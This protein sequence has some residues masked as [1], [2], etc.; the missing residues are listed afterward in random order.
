MISLA[1]L[2]FATWENNIS[3]EDNLN[4]PTD[5]QDYLKK[6]NFEILDVYG[7]YNLEK[8]HKNSER[9]IMIIKKSQS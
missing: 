9:L 7:N 1:G 6:F 5:F 3:Y 4:T 2:E 8:Y